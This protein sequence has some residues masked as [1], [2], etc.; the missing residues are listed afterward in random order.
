[1][2]SWDVIWSTTELHGSLAVVEADP[3]LRQFGVPPGGAWDDY[4]QQIAQFLAPGEALEIATTSWGPSGFWEGIAYEDLTLGLAG[5]E[6]EVQVEGKCFWLPA[7]V[8]VPSGA[9]WR[10]RAKNWGMRLAVGITPVLAPMMRI[11]AGF[12]KIYESYLTYIPVGEPKALETEVGVN[13]SPMGIWL[14]GDFRPEPALNFS[15]PSVCGAIQM[16]EGALLVHGPSGPVTS[17]Y[18]KIGFLTRS[19]I[20]K[21]AQ[22]RPGTKVTLHPTTIE[23]ARRAHCQIQ[24]DLERK[25]SMIRLLES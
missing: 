1:M 25:F 24:D 22:I 5:M 23:D 2:D 20:F 9:R 17:G 11:D 18:P 8:P 10:V 3:R 15:E 16:V 7:R 6:G 4:A 21:L 12:D 13:Q 14:K 19:S